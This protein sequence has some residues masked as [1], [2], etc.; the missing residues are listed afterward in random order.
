MV[1]YHINRREISADFFVIY[2]FQGYMT[3]KLQQKGGI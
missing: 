1:I 3:L 2:M